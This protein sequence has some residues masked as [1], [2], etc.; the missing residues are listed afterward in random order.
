MYARGGTGD[1]IGTQLQ[2][3]HHREA[4]HILMTHLPAELFMCM[5]G[6]TTQCCQGGIHVGYEPMEF[7][8]SPYEFEFYG[9]ESVNGLVNRGLLWSDFIATVKK[10]FASGRGGDLVTVGRAERRRTVLSPEAR[11]DWFH[12]RGDQD[13]SHF[14]LLT[15]DV[16][17]TLFQDGILSINEGKMFGPT[18]VIPRIAWLAS[19]EDTIPRRV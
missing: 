18:S 10:I 2:T 1:E 6:E 11:G 16:E 13:L 19:S 4:V 14:S 9:L 12:R 17:S 15:R 5:S 7:L 8:K 3:D